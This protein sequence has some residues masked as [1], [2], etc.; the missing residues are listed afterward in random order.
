MGC[1]LPWNGKC[2]GSKPAAWLSNDANES[3]SR[4][5]GSGKS[6]CGTGDS[7]I[8]SDAVAVPGR[9]WM[10]MSLHTVS[11]LI[12]DTAERKSCVHGSWSYGSLDSTC[13][14][15]RNVRCPFWSLVSA[16]PIMEITV[17]LSGVLPSKSASTIFISPGSNELELSTSARLNARRSSVRASG[18]TVGGQ[19]RRGAMMQG[20]AGGGRGRVRASAAEGAAEIASQGQL[21]SARFVTYQHEQAGLPQQSR[22]TG[23]ACRCADLA[24]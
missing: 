22:R 1:S 12:A 6:A 17:L 11:V 10:P 19:Q 8:A 24:R 18:G 14:S 3:G 7:A 5:S 16:D 13:T 15:C 9:Y 21:A 20:D 23:C 2:S 4:S